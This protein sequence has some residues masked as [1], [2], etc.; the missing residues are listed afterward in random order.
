MLCLDCSSVLCVSVLRPAFFFLCFGAPCRA[1]IFFVGCSIP[2]NFLRA[3]PRVS[4][5]C[6]LCAPP[7]L[8]F[9]HC[10][11]SPRLLFPL[12]FC[13]VFIFSLVD[14]IIR[15]GSRSPRALL[16][17]SFACLHQSF[18][19]SSRSQC[20]WVPWSAWAAR[21]P[22]R[23]TILL[24]QPLLKVRAQGLCFHFGLPP[25]WSL[26]QVFPSRFHFP[27]TGFV[28]HRCF[29]PSVR[30]GQVLP[31]FAGRSIDSSFMVSVWLLSVITLLLCGSTSL[32]VWFDFV[33]CMWMLAGGSWLCSW[34]TESKSLKVLRFNRS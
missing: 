3:S 28:L 33:D 11:P 29:D 23:E 21:F 31:S 2:I 27:L 16:A 18:I 10:G 25:V 24:L 4:S 7:E 22:A 8:F 26:D 5:V 14:S 1:L 15:A 6:L 12:D 17:L 20:R 19:F 9:T 13:C 34:P 30:L 32:F